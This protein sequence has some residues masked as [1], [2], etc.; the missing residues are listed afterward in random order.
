MHGVATCVDI[1]EIVVQA[2]NANLALISHYLEQTVRKLS[3]TRLTLNFGDTSW[4]STNDSTYDMNN[5]I[6]VMSF[7]MSEMG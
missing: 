5:L 2:W 6:G 3:L 4:A 1:D 7:S